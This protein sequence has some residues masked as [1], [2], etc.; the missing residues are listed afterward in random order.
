MIVGICIVRNEADIL[1]TTVRYHLDQGLG[2]IYVIDNGS[3]D[4]TLKILESLSRYDQRVRWSHDTGQFHQSDAVTNMA[5]EATRN[6]ASWIVPFDA[7][8]FWFGRSGL[9]K[10]IAYHE[11]GSLRAEVVNYVQCRNVTHLSRRAVLKAEYRVHEPRGPAD[12]CRSLVENDEISF[13]E[14]EYP[15]KH[16]S[17]AVVGLEISA[18]NHAISGAAGEVVPVPTIKCLHVPLRA[19]EIMNLKIEQ[20]KRLDAAGYPEWHG[21]HLRRLA[22][23]ADAGLLGEEWTRNSQAEGVL[24]SAHGAIQ[25]VYDPIIRRLLSRYVSGDDR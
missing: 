14:M 12:R 19:Q 22:R 23:M 6:G 2:A 10:E 1:E 17:K 4:G 21:W 13:V 7:D 3:T 8:E 25:L 11:A 24:H 9:A 5:R 15:P 18:G 20:S 16:I